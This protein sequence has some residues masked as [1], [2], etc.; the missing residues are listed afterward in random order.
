[1]WCVGRNSLFPELQLR[2]DTW[3]SSCLLALVF[4]GVFKQYLCWMDNTAGHKQSRI[5]LKSADNCFQREVI[6]PTTQKCSDRPFIRKEKLVKDV[7][8]GGS[9]GCSDH[10][11]VSFVHLREESR[12]ESTAA[13]LNLQRTGFNLLGFAWKNLLGYRSGEKSCWY[14]RI[15]P[16]SDVKMDVYKRWK[17]GQ[18]TWEDC[19]DVWSCRDGVRKGKASLGLILAGDVKCNRKGFYKYINCRRK[20]RENVGTLLGGTGWR[21]TFKKKK[22]GWNTQH[23]CDLSIYL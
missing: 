19:T 2:P 4:S 14:S 15:P 17:Q 18:V 21:R 7:K 10:E 3:R 6:E 16:Y 22:K 8:T 13:T 9:L 5:F 11:V 20:T 12:A 1:M 23:L